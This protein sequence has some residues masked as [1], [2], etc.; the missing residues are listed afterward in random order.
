MVGIRAAEIMIALDG[1]HGLSARNLI[2]G[3]VR[4]IEK[5]EGGEMVRVAPGSSR[6]DIAVMVTD[7]SR[8]ALDLHAGKPVILVAKARS[9]NILAAR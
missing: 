3:T 1:A 8:K 6:L 2:P 7:A 5:V 9:F 4:S